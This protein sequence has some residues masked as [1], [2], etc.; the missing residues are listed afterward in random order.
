MQ[1]A[2]LV[3]GNEAVNALMNAVSKSTIIL[4]VSDPKYWKGLV[5]SK[6]VALSYQHLGRKLSSTFLFSLHFWQ[7]ISVFGTKDGKKSGFY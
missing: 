4:I 7:K 3:L 6:C 2:I 1:P 5:L